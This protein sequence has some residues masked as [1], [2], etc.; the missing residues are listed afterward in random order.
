M[1]FRRVGRHGDR[2][3]RSVACYAFHQTSNGSI[4]SGDVFDKQDADTPYN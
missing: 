2:L 4:Y 3:L 1:G